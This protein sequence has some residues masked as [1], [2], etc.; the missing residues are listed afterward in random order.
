MG[1]E[2]EGGP[3]EV[4]RLLPC[5]AR[6]ERVPEALGGQ[7]EA[8]RRDQA[9]GLGPAQ[10]GGLAPDP[11]SGFAGGRRQRDEGQ[12]GRPIQVQR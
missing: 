8:A 11:S 5:A 2:A 12:I 10:E 4:A 7:D 1:V 6:L 3:F 9:I